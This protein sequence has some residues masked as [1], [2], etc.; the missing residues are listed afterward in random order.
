MCDNS[1]AARVESRL[2]E[3]LRYHLHGLRDK[4][5]RDFSQASFEEELAALH[6]D[7]VYRRWFLDSPQYVLVR[8]MGRISISIGR[9]LGEIYEKIPRYTTAAR[10]DLSQEEVA[11][12]FDNL[13]LDIGIPIESL[14]G[15]DAEHLRSVARSYF[16]NY[17]D[18]DLGIEIR[19]NFNP[20]DSARLRKDDRMANLLISDDYFPIYLVF[21][22]ISPRHEAI[23]RLRRA[24]WNFLIGNRASSFMNEL[25]NIDITR[26]LETPSIRDEIQREVNSIMESLFSSYAFREVIRRRSTNPSTSDLE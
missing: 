15:E 25:M 4:I 23:A 3:A 5:E 17:N 26:I 11:P 24:G 19:Y 20:N 12:R 22:S 14:S 16:T 13:E 1:L 10:F 2:R 6:G 8:F 9:R 7:P 21:S 18:L